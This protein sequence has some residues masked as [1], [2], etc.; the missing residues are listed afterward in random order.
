MKK[1]KESSKRIIQSDILFFIKKQSNLL[2]LSPIYQQLKSL[3]L[4]R[5]Q[6]IAKHHKIYRRS[7]MNR[8]ELIKN[9]E[10]YK[11]ENI[12][13]EEWRKILGADWKLYIEGDFYIFKDNSMI[14][15]ELSR[16]NDILQ[17][18]NISTN[19]NPIKNDL[20]LKDI[21]KKIERK[22]SFIVIKFGT[23][24][25]DFNLIGEAFRILGPELLLLQNNHGTI[26]LKSI[27]KFIIIA[28]LAF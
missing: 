14:I 8:N 26:I 12:T 3:S 5:L 24:F 19:L 22:N 15:G 27:Y 23:Y 20:N 18:Q 13:D 10:L 16:F 6:Q 4:K 28:P 1:E 9:I 11:K 2:E 17:F 21:S 7:R 25:Y